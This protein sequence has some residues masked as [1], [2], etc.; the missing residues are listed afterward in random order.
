MRSLC[1]AACAAA[2]GLACSHRPPADFA[3]DPGLVSR[4]RAIEMQAPTQAC[5]GESFPSSYTAIL[6]DGS[7]IPFA[8]R[9]DR[10]HPPRLH[11][12]FLERQSPDALALEDGGWN[13][14]PDPLASALRGFRLR[15]A[16]YANPAIADSVSIAPSYDCVRHAFTFSGETGMDGPDVVI[17]LGLV[18]S[19]F[20]ARLLVAQIEVAEAPPQFMLADADLVPPSDWLV[21]TSAGGRGARGTG[22]RDGAK[23]A[24]GMAGCPGGDGGPG[25]QGGN[26]YRGGDGGRGGRFTIMVP[27]EEPFMAGLVVA[28]SPGGGEGPGGRGGE[29]G[30]GGR[31]GVGTVRNGQACAAGK[32]G[33]TGVPGREGPPGEAGRPG[34]RPQI[35]TVPQRELFGPRAPAELLQ[36]LELRERQ[37]RR[38]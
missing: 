16:L 25:G 18:R 1:V 2:V 3:P 7:R 24:N 10:K 5:P 26:G 38:P 31:A 17:R 35:L 14:E 9:Y 28:R 23:G 33:A 4:I 30:Q 15:A 29:G 32:D 8:T 34:G 11:V 12:V 6:D 20:V 37:P 19:P 13:A 22:G 21:V 36:L 27:T